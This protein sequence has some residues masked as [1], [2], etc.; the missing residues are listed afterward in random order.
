[1]SKRA[2]KPQSRQVWFK[3]VEQWL[4]SGLSQADF[5]QQNDINIGNFYN[6]SA[7]YRQQRDQ[8]PPV[9][10]AVSEFVPLTIDHSFAS[11]TLHCGDIR[12]DFSQRLQPHELP[13]WIKALRSGLC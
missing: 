2:T 3:R 11:I 5:C 9:S 10:Q 6:W 8:T 7:K 4:Q 1:M 13:L 12:I